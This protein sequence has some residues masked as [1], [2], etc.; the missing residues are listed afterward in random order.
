ME[1]WFPLSVCCYLLSAVTVGGFV[2]LG[3]FL[4]E[5]LAGSKI[6]NPSV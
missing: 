5:Y 6:G 2:C 1:A 3:Q 4:H